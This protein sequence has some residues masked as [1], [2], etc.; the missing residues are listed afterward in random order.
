MDV[1]QLLNGR[2]ADAFS[3]A[4]LASKAQARWDRND[5][6]AAAT[7]FLAA[8]ERARGESGPD[9]TVVYIGRA[10]TTL[11]LAGN[12]AE[13]APMFDS[14]IGYDWVRAGPQLMV[15][16]HVVEWAFAA[17]LETAETA[18]AFRAL[19]AK[20]ERRCAELGWVFPRIH[21]KQD[22]VLDRAVQLGCVDLAER[23]VA[24]IETRRPLT[25]ETADWV[26][27]VRKWIEA[28]KAPSDGSP[29]AG[30]GSERRQ[31]R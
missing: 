3:A 23:L 27:D 22:A 19:Y 10:A 4:E 18:E 8:S 5:Y 17:Q 9:R 16:A 6:L 11:H 2:P 29:G 7:L 25:R 1:R 13:A 20:A 12:R 31:G 30:G 24:R 26:R 28:R 14:V 15:D 21:P